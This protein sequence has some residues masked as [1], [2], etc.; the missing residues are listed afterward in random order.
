MGEFMFQCVN[1]RSKRQ[2]CKFIQPPELIIPPQQIDN[3]E[4]D[5][6]VEIYNK[7]FSKLPKNTKDRYLTFYSEKD[8]VKNYSMFLDAMNE[9]V[10]KAVDF[11]KG[12]F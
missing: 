6:G 11:N 4:Y 7:E 3:G 1:S 9:L 2:Q 10:K 5:F 8:G 12:F